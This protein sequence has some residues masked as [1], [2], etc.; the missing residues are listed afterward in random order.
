M[1]RLLSVLVAALL[2]L[3]VLPTALAVGST[4]PITFS[5]FV[6]HSWFWFNSWGN[7]PCSQEITKV[8]GVPR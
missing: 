7:D 6:D 8:T 5:L 1:K 4:D 2:V 3:S